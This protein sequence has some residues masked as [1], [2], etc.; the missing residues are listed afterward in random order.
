MIS[1]F[2][3]GNAI[4]TG[5]PVVI[6]GKPNA[7][8]ST[9]LNALLNEER[10]IVSDIPG[11]TR[12]IIEDEL[13]IGGIR[14][15]FIDTASLRE[16]TDKIEAIGVE[17]AYGKIK[18]SAIVMYLL[19]QLEVSPAEL[20]G[21]LDELSSDERRVGQEC[22]RTCSCRWSPVTSKKKKYK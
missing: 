2:E 10:A 22:V 3:I 13:V 21:I 9:L 12:D 11:T 14:F 16:T 7:G 20:G 8:K 5:L 6:S 17:R 19:D 18:Q 4:K 1:S 15:R